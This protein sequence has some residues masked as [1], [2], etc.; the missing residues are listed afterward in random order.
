MLAHRT[1]RAAPVAPRTRAALRP[2]RPIGWFRRPDGLRQ[3]R[4]AAAVCRW[5]LTLQRGKPGNPSSLSTDRH[6]S[7]TCQA[8]SIGGE[9][10]G[11]KALRRPG[12]RLGGLGFTV[13]RRSVAYQ[14][15]QQR[16]RRAGHF[17]HGALECGLVGLGRPRETAQL[18]DELK[19]GRADLLVGRR[20]LE[21]VQGL[22]AA[23]HT[24]LL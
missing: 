11:A 18:A 2:S 20:G 9:R 4:A 14:R 19:G 23:A 8:W 5:R 16:V 3:A 1:R 15:I 17:L 10:G 12:S 21:V 13:A 7:R 24:E 22:D 6:P